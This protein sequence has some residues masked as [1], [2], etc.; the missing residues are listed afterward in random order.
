[1]VDAIVLALL[2]LADLGFLIFLRWCRS[3]RVRRARIEESLVVYLR[4]QN[5]YELPKR[6]RL[7]L[8]AS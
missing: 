3:K 2:A 1:M 6:R 8:R 5:G 4:R 7:L